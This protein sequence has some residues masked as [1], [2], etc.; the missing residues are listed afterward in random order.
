MG[1]DDPLCGD[2]PAICRECG[3][4]GPAQYGR[5]YHCNQCGHEWKDLGHE[6]SDIYRCMLPGGE[7]LIWDEGRELWVDTVNGNTYAPGE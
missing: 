4:T 6:E 2:G 1:D 5:T 3:N 7:I